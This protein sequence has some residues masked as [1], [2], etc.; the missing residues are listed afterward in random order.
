MLKLILGCLA[1]FGRFWSFA[2]QVLYRSGS[3]PFFTRNFYRQLAWI[4]TTC[5]APVIVVLG[6]TGATLALQGN[7]IFK[8][9]GAEPMVSSLILVAL[10]RELCP[11]MTGMMLAAQAG[12][13]M[14]AELGTMRIKD[15]I[16]AIEVM[17]VDSLRY[18]VVPR[19]LATLIVC[20][21][22]S[23]VGLMAGITGGYAVSVA[24]MGVN[25]GTFMTNLFL[26]AEPFDLPMILLKSSLF[27]LI[28]GLLSCYRGYTVTGGAAQVG[29]AANNAV[30]EAIVWYLLA[31]YFVTNAVLGLRTTWQW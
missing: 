20:P 5:M 12:S 14:A 28:V 9:F 18:L 7:N 17:A 27:G 3:R 31:N 4:S 11:A 15:E 23:L 10:I 24:V 19:V 26:L 25:S 13:S 22:I 29:R 8:L 2:A 16:D 21:S 1:G 30:L 6:P